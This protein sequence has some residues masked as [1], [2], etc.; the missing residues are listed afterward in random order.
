LDYLQSENVELK[1]RLRRVEEMEERLQ[2]LE[3][4]GERFKKL[5]RAK[6]LI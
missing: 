3:M 4:E 6:S 5:L 2:R 1:A